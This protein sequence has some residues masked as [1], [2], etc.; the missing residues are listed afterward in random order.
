MGPSLALERIRNLLVPRALWA[1]APLPPRADPGAPKRMRRLPRRVVEGSLAVR[2]SLARLLLAPTVGAA[3]AREKGMAS[4]DP[5]EKSASD[6]VTWGPTVFY[7]AL[8]ASL[9]FFWWLLIYSHGV[10][11]HGG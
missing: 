8:L 5:D 3:V 4:R 10:A 9:V 7:G 1:R 11:P 2:F 6:G